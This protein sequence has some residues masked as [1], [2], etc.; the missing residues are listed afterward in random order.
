MSTTAFVVVMGVEI[1][2]AVLLW[3]T[4]VFGV[5]W[6]R[7][8]RQPPRFMIRPLRQQP[9]A[10]PQT[11]AAT[12]TTCNLLTAPKLPWTAGFFTSPIPVVLGSF[13]AAVLIPIAVVFYLTRPGAGRQPV[14]DTVA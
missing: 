9:R 6:R 4:V 1:P 11:F 2:T 5:R 10:V 7:T 14:T 3:A 8:G 13:A 12:V